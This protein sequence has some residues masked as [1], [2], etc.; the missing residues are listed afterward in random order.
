[1]LRYITPIT[2]RKYR[3]CI[4]HCVKWTYL[5]IENDTLQLVGDGKVKVEHGQREQ[6]CDDTDDDKQRNTSRT[7]VRQTETQVK[8]DAMI[9]LAVSTKCS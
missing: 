9:R 7:T 5:G 6:R 2:L 4:T 8:A 1:M 3:Y